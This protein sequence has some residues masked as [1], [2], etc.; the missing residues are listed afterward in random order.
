MSRL[1]VVATLVGAVAAIAVGTASATTS[2]RFLSDVTGEQTGWVV[3][4]Q[5]RNGDLE[6]NV[7]VRRA[8]AN[9]TYQF[10]LWC[11]PSHAT[12]GNSPRQQVG[13]TTNSAGSASFHVSVPA[14]AL[15]VC[16][17]GAHTGHIDLSAVPSI[18][19]H[20]PELVASPIN[21]SS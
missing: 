19:G 10:E 4:K 5:L 15:A 11:G 20:A 8:D 21:F 12:A 16:G 14:W 2:I 9:T 1:M 17:P 3:V 18:E 13:G 6:L 7:E